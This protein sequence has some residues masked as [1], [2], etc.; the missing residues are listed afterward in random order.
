MASGVSVA[1]I[2]RNTGERFRMVR[3]ELG[4]SAFGINQITLAPG[5]R[6]R[7][8]RHAHQEEVYVVL[9]G[10]LTLFVEGDAREYGADEIIRVAPDV[11][12][13]LVN[14][15]PATLVVL[16]LGAAGEHQSRDAEAFTEWSQ[17]QGASPRDVPLP[18]DLDLSN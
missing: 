5:Q 11:R 15:G 8:H 2:D 17:E 18:P 4:V 10:I 13:Q 9:A 3:R 1:K 7:I 16:A 12:R 14:R 6:M